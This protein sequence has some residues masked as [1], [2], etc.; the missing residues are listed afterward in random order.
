[1]PFLKLLWHLPGANYFVNSLAPGD[2][3]NILGNQFPISKLISVIGG[4]GICWETVVK[5]MPQDLSDDKST[6]VQVMAWCR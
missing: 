5:W 1:M 3:N 6:L 4:K 2:P